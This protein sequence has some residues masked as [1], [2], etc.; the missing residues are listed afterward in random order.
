MLDSAKGNYRI[1]AMKM[2]PKPDYV[3]NWDDRLLVVG[4]KKGYGG[5]KNE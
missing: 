4:W 2:L 5:M 1:D 3:G